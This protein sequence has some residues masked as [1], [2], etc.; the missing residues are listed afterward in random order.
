ML[1]GLLL[2]LALAVDLPAANAQITAYPDKPVKIFVGF[3]AGGGTDVAARILAQKLTETLGQSIVVENRPGASGMIAAEALAKSAADGYTLMMGSQTTLAVAPALYRKFSIDAA[4]DFVAVAPAGVS[5]LVLVVHPSV[6]VRSVKELIALG[7]AKPGAI[8]FG[9]GGLGT[10][11][12]MAGELFSLQAGIKMVH[13]AY[14][15]EA[16]AIN[17]LLGGQLDLI[18]AN[19]SAVIGNVKA[20]SLRALAVTSAQRAASAPEI[21]TIAEVALP[22]FEAATWFA[23]VAPAGTPRD[24]VLRLNSEVTRLV[25]QAEVQ[26]RFADLGMTVDATAPDA[27]DGYIKTEIAKWSKVIKDADI[28][29]LE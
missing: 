7:K 24:I 29:A 28:R 13:V 1:L 5:P 4:R 2:G 6:P 12:H 23:L 14:R 25:G 20:G 15:G 11:P 16:P 18:F 21:P 22:G 27:L 9:S 19:L 3:A 17:D 10:T 26:Q 8:N